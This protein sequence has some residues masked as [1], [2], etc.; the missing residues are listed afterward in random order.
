MKPWAIVL[1]ILALIIAITALVLA[2]IWRKKK[3]TNPSIPS[4]MDVL[5]LTTLGPVIPSD[6]TFEPSASVSYTI[7]SER[8]DP[9][10]VESSVV[11]E[12]SNIVATRAAGPMDDLVFG[13]D[14]P[15]FLFGDILDGPFVFMGNGTATGTA[16]PGPIAIMQKPI[17]VSTNPGVMAATL[18]YSFGGDTVPTGQPIQLN[19]RISF[20]FRTTGA[21]A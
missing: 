16:S 12:S 4:Q 15:K 21:A 8:L 2:I 18:H 13:F 5:P 10:T 19:F 17:F 20:L 6:V 3:D 9:T 7:V 1:L 11:I 14:L